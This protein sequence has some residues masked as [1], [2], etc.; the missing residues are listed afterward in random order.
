MKIKTASLFEDNE[1]LIELTHNFGGTWTQAKLDV[2]K[3]YLQSFT[4][5]FQNKSWATTIYIDACA[6]TGNCDIKIKNQSFTIAGSAKLA[7]ETEPTFSQVVFIEKNKKRFEHLIRLKNAFP[8]A[9]I[10]VYRDD[11]NVILPKI[12]SEKLSSTHRG[13]IFVDPYGMNISWDI[14]QSI[15]NTKKL[16]V[17]YLFPLSGLYRQAAINREDVD[18]KKA[19]AILKLMG[20]LNW[21]AAL[22]RKNPIQDM[23]GKPE[24]VERIANVDEIIN[25][26]TTRLKTI[27]PYVSKPLILPS[28]G[29]RRY[30]FYFAISNDSQPAQALA[31]R[32]SSHILKVAG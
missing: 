26:V 25:Y 11:C 4:K 5:V 8:S 14:I 6:G 20:D 10:D 23:F 31:K 28:I 19:S 12:L 9:S 30:A 13:V 24:V 32:I 2:L 27:F 21:E 18:E 16:D 3:Q 1:D 15:A 22:Y 17:W 29:P 7:L